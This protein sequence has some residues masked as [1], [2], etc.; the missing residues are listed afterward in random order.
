MGD[1]KARQSQ[2]RFPMAWSQRG[3]DNEK[4]VMS[5]KLES[6]NDKDQRRLG[7]KESRGDEPIPTD[8]MDVVMAYNR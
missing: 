8:E 3:T 2:D 7:N 6:G 1:K 4:A 5:G